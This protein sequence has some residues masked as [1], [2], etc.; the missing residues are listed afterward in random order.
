M[1]KTLLF[2]C[3]AV[4]LL[5]LVYISMAFMVNYEGIYQKFRKH[6]AKAGFNIKASHINVERFP[7]PRIAVSGI[8]IDDSITA[9][10]LEIKFSPLSTITFNPEIEFVQIDGVKAYVSDSRID[11]MRHNPMISKLLHLVP[12]LPRMKMNNIKVVDNVTKDTKVLKNIIV[13]PSSLGNQ[14]TLNWERDSVTKISYNVVESGVNVQINYS[15][16]TYDMKLSEVYKQGKLKNGTLRYNVKNLQQ[17]MADRYQD[18]DLLIT[19]IRSDQPLELNCKFRVDADRTRFTDIKVDSKSV[20]MTGS[21]DLFD[22]R[23]PDEINL[24]FNHFDFTELFDTPNMDNVKNS[25]KKEKLELYDVVRNFNIK[26]NKITVAG[27]YIK[28]FVVQTSIKNDKMHIKTFKGDIGQAEGKFDAKGIV[29]QNQYR[30]LFD[31]NVHFEHKDLN[32]ILSDLGYKEYASRKEAPFSLTS[33]VEATPIDY[34]LDNLFMKVGAFNASG[35]AAIK[36]IGSIPRV[37][38]SL[39]LSALDLFDKDIPVLNNVVQYFTS[40]TQDMKSRD[41]LKKYIPIREMSYLGD[42]DITFNNILINNT[43]VDKLRLIAA[44]SPGNIVLNSVYYQDEG[45]YL[46]G[47]GYLSAA[48]IKPKIEF[49]VAESHLITDKFDIANLMGL[50][51]NLYENYDLEKVKFKTDFRAQTIKQKDMEFKNF[52]V[53]ARNNGILWNIDSLRGSFADGNFDAT[54]SLRMDAMNINLAYAYNDFN[55]KKL[56]RLVP[57]NIFGIEDGW[58]SMNGMLSTNGRNLAELFYNLYTKS[59]FLAKSVLWNNFNIDG[60]VARTSETNYDKKDIVKDANYFMSSPKTTMKYLDGELE[61]DKGQFKI[62]DID[63]ETHRS[64]AVSDVHYDMYKA[65]LTVNT[66]FL[67]RP[68]ATSLYDKNL[69]IRFPMTINGSL[70]STKKEFDF[71]EYNTY[72]ERKARNRGWMKQQQFPPQLINRQ[73]LQEI[74]Q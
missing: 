47:V 12:K 54:G 15:G 68:K 53:K 62:S 50:V 1:K 37:N 35:D 40:L 8:S 16:P 69:D 52:R 21:V 33:Y 30:S 28:D 64:K 56:K 73:N 60:L 10:S 13:D 24:E 4:T 31:G 46:T 67:L 41:Y 7:V 23:T 63:F 20:D 49:N 51:R 6:I 27:T 18:V 2:S 74:P 17:F 57:F 72:L 61:L 29:T 19:K 5:Y 48:G 38:L 11:F 39:S 65:D 9:K 36:L 44:L 3:V 34:K 55:L 58:M 26:A 22:S 66:N 59:A 70:G 45:S 43:E 14:V 32:M 71:K 25:K 42:F